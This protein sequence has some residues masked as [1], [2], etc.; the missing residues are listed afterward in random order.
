MNNLCEFWFEQKDHRVSNTIIECFFGSRRVS[1]QEWQGGN[2]L[3]P[4]GSPSFATCAVYNTSYGVVNDE[5]G[6]GEKTSSGYFTAT[7]IILGPLNSSAL[8]PSDSSKSAPVLGMTSVLNFSLPQLTQ[9]RGSL[10]VPSFISVASSIISHV[11][12]SISNTRPP[13][14]PLKVLTTRRFPA[15]G[16]QSRPPYFSQMVSVPKGDDFHTIPHRAE[17]QVAVQM[18]SCK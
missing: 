2:H 7:S 6:R 18:P 12:P 13:S 17:L 9:Q 16:F 4:T 15:G 8:L 11:S 10:F 3:L 14:G 1:M 5:G